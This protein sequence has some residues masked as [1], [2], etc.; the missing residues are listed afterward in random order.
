M[1]DTFILYAEDIFFAYIPENMNLTDIHLSMLFARGR[2][3]VISSY[4]K[5]VKQIIKE[6]YVLC[7][8]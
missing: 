8:I 5:L 4:H 3:L 1:S 2:I 7:P 6:M